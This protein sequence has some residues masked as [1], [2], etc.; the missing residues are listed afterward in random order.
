MAKAVY[1]EPCSLFKPTAAS[2]KQA[3]TQRHSLKYGHSPSYRQPYIQ[4]Y[5]L[6]PQ[7]KQT[8]WS[9]AKERDQS[10]FPCVLKLPPPTQ[11]AIYQNFKKL[12]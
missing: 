3:Q 2:W 9:T 5:P 10:V 8:P 11:A 6:K 1:L 4:L 7:C 12:T